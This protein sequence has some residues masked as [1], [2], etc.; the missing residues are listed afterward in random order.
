VVGNRVYCSSGKSQTFERLVV[1]CVDARTGKKVWETETKLPVWGSPTV[2][3]GRV[4]VGLGN[5]RIL[6]RL[7]EQ[8]D[9]KGGVLCL[10]AFD[11]SPQWDF[12]T[13]GSVHTKPVCDGKR[14]FVGS[15]DRH[16]YA[17]DCRS[18]K[19][20]WKRDLG[21]EVE[22]T[23]ALA[24]ASWGDGP[25]ALYVASLDGDLY[26]LDPA[27][28]D[29]FWHHDELT[30]GGPDKKGYSATVVSGL[31][32]ETRRTKQGEERRVYFAAGTQG[33]TRAVV[34]C[35]EEEWADEGK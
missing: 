35:L 27:R 26:C 34:F 1:F 9:P 17:L 12:P 2:H 31:A 23:P 21:S 7:N 10:D 8:K 15:Q 25:G 3:D 20:V 4:F 29:V 6:E 24:G 5:A 11:G 33:M 19:V 13:K 18:G 16:C 28:G 14:V 22:S 32:V 30:R